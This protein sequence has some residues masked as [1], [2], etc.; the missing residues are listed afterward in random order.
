MN[1]ILSLLI[2]LVLPLSAGAEDQDTEKSDADTAAEAQ[3][4]VVT[5]TDTGPKTMSG[6]SILGNEETP[7]SL[8]IVPWKSSEL[9]DDIGLSDSL[10]DNAQPVDKEVFLRELEYFEIRSSE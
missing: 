9:G 1:K 7:K 6:M 5:Q 4:E 8:V 2:V 10:G 3:E